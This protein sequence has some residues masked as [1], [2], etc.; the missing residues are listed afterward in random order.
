[1]I[2]L[3]TVFADISITCFTEVWC[4]CLHHSFHKHIQCSSNPVLTAKQI[5]IGTLLSQWADSTQYHL[6]GCQ[7]NIYFPLSNYPIRKSCVVCAH[8]VHW[9][10]NP[11]PPSPSK[12]P[13]CLFFTKPPLN[14]Q[15]VPATPFWAIS[16]YILVFLRT[17]SP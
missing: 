8:S 17:P 7:E 1:M 2:S 5:L 9:G 15:T 4:F 13:P 12:T 10:I 6:S 3:K 16:P 14:L 11:P